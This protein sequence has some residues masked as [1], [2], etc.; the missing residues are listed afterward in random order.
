[1]A[2][3]V[4]GDCKVDPTAQKGVKLTPICPILRGLSRAHHWAWAK[5]S[6]DFE[7][8]KVGLK[9]HGN[10]FYKNHLDNTQ[11]FLSIV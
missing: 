8:P 5:F 1:M 4:G 11:A 10:D 2:G 6:T 7:R 9:D 3:G